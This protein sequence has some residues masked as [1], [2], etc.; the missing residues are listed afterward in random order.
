MRPPISTILRLTTVALIAFPAIGAATASAQVRE[1][2]KTRIRQPELGAIASMKHD[3][4]PFGKTHDGHE[5]KLHPL[6]NLHG[7]RIKLI[8]YGATLISVETPDRSGKTT[9][10]TLGFPTLDG[11]LQRHPFFGSTVGRYAN[12]IAGG[13][14]TLD[15]KPY[16]L[17]T[18]N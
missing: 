1:V 7:M 2:D 6:T 15:G 17:A 12:R 9:N 10:I 8:D 11:Y 3:V 13:K 16:T 18:N 14:F 5:V 4:Q